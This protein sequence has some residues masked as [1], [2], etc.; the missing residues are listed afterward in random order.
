MRQIYLIRHG[1]PDF[2]SGIRL[3]LGR[4]DLPLAPLGRM[5]ACLLHE[6]LKAASLSSVFSSPLLRS[7]ETAR[8][9]E[10]AV[11]PLDLLAEQNMGIWDGLS[12]DEIRLAW[13]ELYEKRGSD[14]LLVPPGAELLADVQKRALT[15]LGSC[16]SGS[17]GDI[18]VV[19]HASVIE[20][21]LSHFS[22]ASLAES[23]KYRLPYGG[24]AVLASGDSI[25]ILESSLTPQPAMTPSLAEALLAA[26]G[27]GERISAHCR[28]VAFKA[29]E[30]ADAVSVPVS[31]DTVYCAALLH[32]IARQYPTHADTGADW[33]QSLGYPD[34]S[35]LI[36]QHHDLSENASLEA[37]ILYIS[38]KC[39]QEDCQV[40][41]EVRFA[42][43]ALHCRD[44]AAAAS[45]A[46]RLKTARQVREKINRLCGFDIVP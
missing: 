43:S 1:T 28:A 22:G 35:L 18:A 37:L 39:I 42:D 16:I 24:Y 12:F 36:R 17:S 6:T 41:L 32:D 40:P 13:P 46:R 8:A 27:P 7:L 34:I 30:I 10:Q 14:P 25:R 4:T 26:A 31:R 5:Q 9:L 38:D 2:P 3:C 33:L 21:L 19:T 15:A 11:T 23:R 44:S 45:H 29:A 20:S